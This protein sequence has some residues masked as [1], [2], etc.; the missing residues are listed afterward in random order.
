MKSA[1]NDLESSVVTNQ[2]LPM[3][4]QHMC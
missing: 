1:E 2:H 4:S 3:W